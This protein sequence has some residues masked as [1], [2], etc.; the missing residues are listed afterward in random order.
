MGMRRIRD[1]VL[2]CPPDEAAIAASAMMDRAQ[3]MS[4]DR[5]LTGLS[6]SLLI[7]AEET[8]VPV[9]TVL[10]AA[11]RMLRDADHHITGSIRI[12]AI[13]DLI[14]NELKL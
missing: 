13:R 10:E 9:T 3:N 2:K 1:A 4:A 7:Y 6:V 5:A 8:G 11:S 14:G 12:G